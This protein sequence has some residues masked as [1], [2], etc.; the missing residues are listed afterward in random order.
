MKN[1]YFSYWLSLC[2]FWL[3]SLHFSPQVVLAG[4]STTK[5][6]PNFTKKTKRSKKNTPA[7]SNPLGSFFK[8]VFRRKVQKPKSTPLISSIELK[9]L[10]R[11]K[12]SQAQ[13][14][15]FSQSGEAFSKA[16]F[17][18]DLQRLRKSKLF[19][20]VQGFFY[21]G[22]HGVKLIFQFKEYPIWIKG[23]VFTGNKGLPT[24]VLQYRT[25]LKPGKP[26]IKALVKKEAK[27]ILDL[28]K[29]WGYFKVKIL[30]IAAGKKPDLWLKFAITERASAAIRR[31]SIRG[32][33]SISQNEL[34][35]ILVS[36][37]PGT[38]LKWT[39][40]KGFFLDSPPGFFHPYYANQ[41]VQRLKAYYAKRGFL[42]VKVTGPKIHVSRTREQVDLTYTV[43]EGKRYRYGSFT[44]K[45]DILAPTKAIYALIKAKPGHVFHAGKLLRESIYPI[46]DYYRDRGYAHVQIYAHYVDPGQGNR[47]KVEIQISKGPLVTIRNIKI[48]GNKETSEAVIHRY[49]QLKPGDLYSQAKLR[50]SQLALFRTGFFEPTDRRFGVKIALNPAL[51]KKQVDL[52]VTLKEKS[53][54]YI[55]YHPRG[56]NVLPGIGYLSGIGALFSLQMHRNNFL[57]LGQSIRFQGMTNHNLAH[58]QAQL[59]WIEPR[60]FHTELYTSISLSAGNRLFPAS[61]FSQ[62]SMGGRLTLSY[63]IWKRNVRLY[64][65]YRLEQISIVPD[66]SDELITRMKGLLRSRR[67]GSLRLTLSYDSRR[68]TL[69][70]MSGM[71]HT[72]SFEHTAPYLGADYHLNRLE[73]R[74]RL[75]ISL[76][77]SL[78]LRSAL[79]VG[80]L[81]SQSP[82]GIPLFERFT[83]GGQFSLRG[84]LAQSIAPRIVAP[85]SMEASF[86][87]GSFL[88][89]GNKQLL[90]NNEL[91]FP[92]FSLGPFLLKGL[93]FVD[94]GNTYEKGEFF[95]QDSRNPNL[96]LGLYMSAGVGLHLGIGGR[97]VIRLEWGFPLTL[98]Q[99]EKMYP[100]GIIM[101]ETTF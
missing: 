90:L 60:L 36:K 19:K 28:Y 44:V 6:K 10:N 41:D 97:N 95:F 30:V 81:Q 21:P 3:I 62:N 61:G 32:N 79:T 89:G 84:Y 72:L 67:A 7:K 75:Y 101:G 51:N 22:S 55:P 54:R 88:A 92:L 56:S 20:S 43:I 13:Q 49:L 83:M 50:K 29:Q 46:R 16:L 69:N 1:P 45:G 35:Q 9:G 48:S 68:R 70:T 66:G 33:Q 94:A 23:I 38:R 78:T 40:E 4:K 99:N 15:I 80:W 17:R 11:I 14:H 82:G 18:R 71:F 100:F 91:H 65:T 93:F 76:M 74:G 59:T 31:V 25:L 39:K 85:S 64:G 63:P 52:H 34:L 47:L 86:G 37:R 2:A 87:K 27:R 73:F 53:Q 42:H 58:W 57:G 24:H 12:S 98:R 5:A 26:L 8:S 77:R 96:P